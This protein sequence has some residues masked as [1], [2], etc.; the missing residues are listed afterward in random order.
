MTI[1]A[2]ALQFRC[3]AYCNDLYTLHVANLLSPATLVFHRYVVGS[4]N[5][6]IQQTAMA[7]PLRPPGPPPAHCRPR[8]QAL[9]QITRSPTM[10]P[11]ERLPLLFPEVGPKDPFPLQV[12]RCL[13][14]CMNLI[15]YNIVPPACVVTSMVTS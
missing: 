4:S 3:H 2:R 1:I 8:G 11:V 6:N 7:Y 12:R 13:P 10:V 15:S 5:F 9:P 14:L